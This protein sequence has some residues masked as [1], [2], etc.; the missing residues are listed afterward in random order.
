M[1]YLLWGILGDVGVPKCSKILS[2]P[3]KGCIEEWIK[4]DELLSG[5]A[6]VVGTIK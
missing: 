4:L 3:I 1:H 6:N 2:F 5:S